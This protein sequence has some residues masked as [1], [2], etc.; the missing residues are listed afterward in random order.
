MGK[1]IRIVGGGLA[2]LTL[3][4]LL[5]R[6]AVP[7]QIHDAATYPRQ[8]VC[9]EFIS[10]RGLEILSSLAISNLPT[11]LGSYAHAIRFFDSQESS[12][13]LELPRPALAIDRATLDHLLAEEFERQGGV[14]HQNN[15][16]SESF[17]AEGVVR[18][19]GRRLRKNGVP[20]LLGIKAHAKN[21]PLNSDLELYFSDAGYIGL[22][23]QPG[24]A[25]NVCALFRD[26]SQLRPGRS[27]ERNI[28]EI[29]AAQMGPAFQARIANA[30]FDQSTFAAVAGI[31]LNR[32]RARST[33][34]CR[35]GDSICMIP[36]MTGNGMS[37]AMESAVL[38]AP[39]LRDYS[40]GFVEWNT[41][42]A[43]ISSGCDKTFRRRLA[44]ADLLQRACF[45]PAGRKLLLFMV[46]SFP[47]A[48][49][50]WFRLTR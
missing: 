49:G 5:R 25:V 46:R 1:E 39:I 29:F 28:N 8:R 24:G 50:C 36:P 3:G 10:G 45:R 12:R 18:A 23:R 32:E 34:E 43:R 41:A 11:P 16:W 21:I 38:A 30:Q 44:V 33:Q 2:G 14:L 19:T 20:G 47:H 13:V 27:S 6:D 22:S 7:V 9:G 31:S 4:I 17:T 37:I 48:L 35:I 40:R 42:Q 26:N 15:R